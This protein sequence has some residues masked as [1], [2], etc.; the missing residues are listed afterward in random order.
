MNLLELQQV[1]TPEKTLPASETPDKSATCLTRLLFVLILLPF[2][3]TVAN[4]LGN[5]LA[6]YT[7]KTIPPLRTIRLARK[8]ITGILIIIGHSRAP[9]QAGVRIDAVYRNTVP[10]PDGI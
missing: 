5:T 2:Q 3:N 4:K 10:T 1:I 7:V 9:K 8:R 6:W